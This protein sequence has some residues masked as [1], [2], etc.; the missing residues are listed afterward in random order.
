[1]NG[2]NQFAFNNQ[3]CCFMV[4]DALQARFWAGKHIR[5]CGIGLQAEKML[6]YRTLT[7]TFTRVTTIIA[8][9]T[10]YIDTT[11]T[12][13]ETLDSLTNTTSTYVSQIG[14][15]PATQTIDC[16]VPIIPLT[17]SNLDMRELSPIGLCV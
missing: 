11:I 17:G 1:M 16:N 4:Q 8:S 14:S 12:S 10:R 13:W 9:V 2:T 3:A 6:E 15:I 7:A 5:C